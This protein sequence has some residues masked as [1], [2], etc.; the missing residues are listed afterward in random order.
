MSS[1]QHEFIIRLFI[2]LLSLNINEQ[3]DEWDSFLSSKIAIYKEHKENEEIA[4][5]TSSCVKKNP[6]LEIN[7]TPLNP[8]TL[9]SYSYQ[10]VYPNKLSNN[11]NNNNKRVTK[12]FSLFIL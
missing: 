7:A 8:I 4:C 12:T 6:W 1:S 3:H 5:A 11:N 2:A 9:A 10:K